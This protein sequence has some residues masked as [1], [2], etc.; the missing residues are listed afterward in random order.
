MLSIHSLTFVPETLAL[1]AEDITSLQDE[2]GFFAN[3]PE[4]NLQ[5]IAPHVL[6]LYGGEAEVRKRAGIGTFKLLQLQ[7]QSS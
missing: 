1:I 2:G 5:Q 6:V 7:W 4:S 3:R